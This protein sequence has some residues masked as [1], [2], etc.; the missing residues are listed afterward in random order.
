MK[1]GEDQDARSELDRALERLLVGE[2]SVKV[3]S[4]TGQVIPT[5]DA[6][7]SALTDPEDPPTIP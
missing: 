6:E 2:V 3:D 5:A 4:A 1:S 7:E